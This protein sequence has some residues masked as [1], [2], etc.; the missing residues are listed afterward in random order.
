MMEAEEAAM[1]H[2]WEYVIKAAQNLHAQGHPH[3]TRA[4][5][6]QEALRLGWPHEAVTLGTHISDHMRSDRESAAY[7]YLDRV[8]RNTYQLNE[9]GRRAVQGL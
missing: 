6:L 2:A 9:A 8:A 1:R 3:L 7:P 5:L 4:Q